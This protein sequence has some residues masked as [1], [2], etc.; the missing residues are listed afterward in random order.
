MLLYISNTFFVRLHIRGL[1]AKRFVTG[2]V[3]F[4]LAL[5]SYSPRTT[6]PI[7][8]KLGTTHPW[9]KETHVFY[10]NGHSILKE[11]LEV[12]IP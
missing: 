9:V 12:M 4:L 1:R 3:D 6:R 2:K 7:S 10:K 11:E 5:L 8:T